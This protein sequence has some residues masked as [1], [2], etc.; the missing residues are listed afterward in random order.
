MTDSTIDARRWWAK[1]ILV[2]G[3][4]AVCCVL[5][6]ALGVR[7]GL[8]PYGTGFTFLTGAAVLSAL[9]V[10]LGAI[11]YLV[12]L[13]KGLRAERP[14]ILIG[15]FIGAVILAQLWSQYSA[16]SSFPVI[17]NIS[18]DTLNPPT[19]D[20]LV[21]VREAEAANPL[22]YDAEVLAEQQKAAYPDVKTLNSTQ[23]SEVLFVQT[24][25]VFRDMGI[26]IVNENSSSGVIEGTDTTFW[27]GFKDD[28]VVRIQATA[29]G[30]D[31]DIRSV[32]RVGRS[33]LGVNAKRINAILDALKE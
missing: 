26:E 18:T 13:G 30:S 28:V 2:G 10:S 21:A 33:D 5:I 22:A 4:V 16:L 14:G 3:V 19:F 11:A 8:W 32:S 25:A 7:I 27:F 9:S 24:L 6:G 15:I 23:T 29:S 12:C 1:A 17:H 20:V 31:V